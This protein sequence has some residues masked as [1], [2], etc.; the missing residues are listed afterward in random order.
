MRQWTWAII[1]NRSYGTKDLSK[2]LPILQ[3]IKVII[4]LIA[5]E[6]IPISLFACV[7]EHGRNPILLSDFLQMLS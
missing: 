4:L 5:I 2:N 3:E 6:A 7:R 1:E